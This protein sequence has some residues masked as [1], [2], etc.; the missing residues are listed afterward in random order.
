[1]SAKLGTPVPADELCKLLFAEYVNDVLARSCCALAKPVAR[2]ATAAIK[3]AGGEHSIS[4]SGVRFTIVT[5]LAV[6]AG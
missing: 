5:Q 4:L 6:T 1:M 3:H 2:G